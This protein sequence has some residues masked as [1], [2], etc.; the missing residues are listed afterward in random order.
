M[1]RLAILAVLLAALWAGDRGTRA[2]RAVFSEHERQEI[3]AL[4]P[5]E[6]TMRLLKRAVNHYEGAAELLS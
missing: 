3:D 2:T 5:Q 6:Q 1:P 4:P